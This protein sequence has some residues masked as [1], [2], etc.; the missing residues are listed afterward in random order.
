MEHLAIM[1]KSWGLTDK[2]LSG[3]KKIESRWYKS[4]YPPWDKIKERE[5]VYFK[6]SGEQVSVKAEVEKV[7]QFSDLN[8]DKVREILEGY[9]EDDG[10]KKD[11]IAEFFELF[12]DKKYCMLIFLK[13]PQKIKPFEIDKKGFGMMS[14][15]I[16]VNDINT[17]KTQ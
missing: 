2:I 5:L 6:D 1:K 3:E 9:G 13:N 11:K 15:W 16:C 10:I 7:L 8:P 4:K 14:A 17:L 12:K